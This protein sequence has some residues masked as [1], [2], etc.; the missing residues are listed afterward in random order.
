[1][2]YRGMPTL[3]RHEP[4]ADTLYREVVNQIRGL[5][6]CGTLRPG[7]RIPSVRRFS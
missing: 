1:M 4:P 2:Q 6:D 5:I 3:L 7:E